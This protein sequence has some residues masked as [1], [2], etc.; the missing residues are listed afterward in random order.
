MIR[1]VVDQDA[2]IFQAADK[3]VTIRDASPPCTYM[4]YCQKVS[5]LWTTSSV[6]LP[7]CQRRRYWASIKVECQ[8]I[9]S[10]SRR[11]SDS[12]KRRQ[13]TDDTIFMYLGRVPAGTSERVCGRRR[14]ALSV[15][16]FCQAHCWRVVKTRPENGNKKEWTNYFWG[17]R[18][19]GAFKSH[20]AKTR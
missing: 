4:I 6:E 18:P 20:A 8:L 16:L 11:P 7:M 2:N 12:G 13:G 17:S 5:R 9:K 3:H 14:I 19:V 10:P 15:P 1:A